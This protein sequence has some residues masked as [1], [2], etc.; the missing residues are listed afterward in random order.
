MPTINLHEKYAPALE[1]VFSTGSFVKGNTSNH[2]DFTGAR[3]VKVSTLQTTALNDY[4]RGGSNRYGTPE[5]IGEEVQEL[6][7][8]Q[9]KAFTGTVD[10]GNASDQVIKNKAA[11]WLREE[12]NTEVRPAADKY[13]LRKYVMNAHI[14]TISAAPTKSNI[15]EEVANAAMYL[16]DHLVPESDRVIYVTT[17]IYKFI[18]LSPEFLGVDRL[19]EKSL[20]KG[21]C[22]EVQGM[23]VIR[24]P[25]S[26][27]PVNCYFLVTHKQSVIFP[28]KL[29]ESKV[30]TDPPGISGA[31]VEG[32]QYY[33]AFVMAAK[34]DGVYAL[35]K[36][37]DKLA[38]PTFA[39]T[40]P[41]TDPVTITCANASIIKYTTDGSDPRFS[42][43]AITAA[44][45]ATTGLAKSGDSITVR[46]VGFA[47]DKF[48]SDVAEQTFKKS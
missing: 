6:T 19:G 26:F 2:I 25:K 34:C 32:R 18:I 13:A 36:A 42:D 46:A 41:G 37:S 15:Q 24:V 7:M 12:I 31:L 17:E 21:E 27:L 40:T 20:A 29:S 4:K 22:G 10:K 35:V 30:H 43:K 3:T 45:V 47:D 14:A 44:S 8:S 23:K 38:T 16:D 9:D 1:S 11:L 33:D 5:E 28:Y 39:C 48:T